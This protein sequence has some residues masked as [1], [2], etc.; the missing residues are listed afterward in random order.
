MANVR[1]ILLVSLHVIWWPFS[2]LFKG[3]AFLLA[4]LWTLASFVLLPFIHLAHTVINIVT[5]PFSVQ[6]LERIEVLIDSL[7]CSRGY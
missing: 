4:P 1:A 5:F 6:W 3:I 7:V 2:K